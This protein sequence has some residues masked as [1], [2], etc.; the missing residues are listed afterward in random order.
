MGFSKIFKFFWGFFIIKKF[1][2]VWE[3]FKVNEKKNSKKSN[4]ANVDCGDGCGADDE[5][6]DG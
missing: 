6:S 3:L 4:V 2:P 5:W 1:P